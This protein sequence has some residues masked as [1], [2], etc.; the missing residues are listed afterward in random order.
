MATWKTNSPLKARNGCVQNMKCLISRQ[1]RGV[2]SQQNE[3]IAF[4]PVP[5]ALPKSCIL[6]LCTQLAASC[7]ALLQADPESVEGMGLTFV[8][9]N[10][11]LMG[12]RTYDPAGKLSAQP[13]SPGG[14]QTA[15]ALRLSASEPPFR[16]AVCA[17]P[18]SHSHHDCAVAPTRTQTAYPPRGI[19]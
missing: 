10:H 8:A 4:V 13:E 11:S 2:N 7:R 5:D 19:L 6:L 9:S 3:Q 15:Q 18:L 1:A 16:G 12:G 14:G 17:S